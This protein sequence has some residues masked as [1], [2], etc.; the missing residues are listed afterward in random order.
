MSYVG[1]FAA[2]N[3]TVVLTENVLCHDTFFGYN[4]SVY[5]ARFTY[6][7]ST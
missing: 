6:E 2:C 5:S 1:T 7:L 4:I 3:D